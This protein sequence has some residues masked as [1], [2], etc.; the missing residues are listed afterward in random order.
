MGVNGLQRNEVRTFYVNSTYHGKGVGRK[1]MEN[2]EKIAK[3]RGIKK[4]IVKSSLY[5]VGFYEKMGFKKVKR[6][7]TKIGKVKFPEI[8]MEKKI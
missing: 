4:L 7:I 5:A 3:K 8:V 6:I 2:V 1:L